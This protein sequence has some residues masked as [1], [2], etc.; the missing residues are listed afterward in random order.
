M[1]EVG[2]PLAN[3]RIV[4]DPEVAHHLDHP[5]VEVDAAAAAAAGADRRPLVHQRRE[6]DRPAVVDVAEAVV[7]GHAHVVE[8]DLVEARAAGHLPQRTHL[9]AGRLHVDDEAG[10]A[11][12]LGQVGIGAGDDLAD[13]AVVRAGRPHLLTGDHPLVTVAD[14]SGL[15]AGQVAAGTRLAEQLAG[16]DVGA[17]HRR[18]VRL[19]GRLAAVGQDRRRHHSET[20]GER[21]LVGH[22]VLRLQGVPG[23]LVGAGQTAA[24][25]LDRAGDPSEPGVEL[26]APPLAG[27]VQIVA[28]VGAVALLEHRD[29]VGALSPHERSLGFLLADVGIEE[30]ASR[31][32]EG[33][34]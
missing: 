24:A 1:I 12:V 18:E 33:I 8:E 29:L 20:D 9:D 5:R 22:L 3:D 23:L 32:L 25:V 13:V 30:L 27:A 7:I 10:E 14:C 11:L 17:V 4:A 2:E 34:E 26:L 15:Q 28:L 21:R 31:F 6:G 16:H 19:L